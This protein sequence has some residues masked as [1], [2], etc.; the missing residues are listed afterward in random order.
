M[1]PEPLSSVIPH[2]RPIEPLR[3]VIFDCDGV[4]VDSEGP[5]ARVCAEEITRIGWPM[6]ANDSMRLFV[7]CNLSDMLP[8]I[9]GHLGHPVP[10]G[11]VGIL[12]SRVIEAM[13]HEAEPM[14]G[15][16]EVLL[17]TAALGL[18]YRVASNSSHEE[19]AVKFA[20]T[21]LAP[22]VVGRVHSYRDVARG[23]PAPDVFLAA[24]AAE[25]IPPSACIVVEDSLPGVT[26]AVAAGM[27]VLGLD[28]HGDGAA[29]LAAGARPIR[30]LSDCPA[31]FRT[32]MLRAA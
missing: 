9:E 19:M 24:A 21:G 14:P 5:A 1:T 7:G 3:L 25:G 17:A 8:I 26:A 13:A 12:R 31:L 20:R 18:P 29:L 4:L 28:L 2:P 10:P 22:L 27:A 11:W 16:A 30:A 23:K 32:A 15:A 6:T